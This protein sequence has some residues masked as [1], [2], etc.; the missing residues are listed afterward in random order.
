[1]PATLGVL[2][3]HVAAQT[4]TFQPEG[5]A[6]MHQSLP[7]RQRAE[8]A[9]AAGAQSVCVDLRRCTY[10]DS[11]FLGTLLFLLRLLR[12]Q[13]PKAFT[14]V[15][16][17]PAC[18]EI[19]QQMGLHRVYP[20]VTADE[21]AAEGWEVVCIEKADMLCFQGNIVRAHQ[22][23]AELPGPTGECFKPVAQCLTHDW[24]EAEKQRREAELREKP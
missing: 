6:T 17:S 8:Q 7:L 19:L 4:V 21:P 13:G 1:M 16:P 12:P 24:E 20:I 2:R 23:L 3:V 5:R 22:E 10:M 14:L 9:L 11:T 18:L 15:C